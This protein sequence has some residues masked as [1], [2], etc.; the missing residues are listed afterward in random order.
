MV[1]SEIDNILDRIL[2]EQP[3]SSDT[4]Q[5]DWLNEENIQR[6]FLDF[7]S[8]LAVVELSAGTEYLNR[9]FEQI[10]R[11]GVLA[12]GVIKE[13]LEDTYNDKVYV[14]LPTR[15]GKEKS[16]AVYA[17]PLKNF[18]L[19][20]F[21][22]IESDIHQEELTSLRSRLEELEKLS[23]TDPLT[24]AWNRLPLERSVD[25]E[26]SRSQRYHHP[27][28][29][30][31]FDVDYFKKVNDV[32]GHAVGDQVL[33]SLVAL[34]R[35]NIRASDSIYRWGGE[36]FVLLATSTHHRAGAL[37]AEK[38]RR[39]VEEY[40][41]PEVGKVTI[42][43]G[44]AEFLPGDSQ[45]SWFRRADTSLYNAKESGRNCVVVDSFGGSDI[46][47]T[48]HGRHVVE[49]VWH[50]IYECGNSVID[51]QHEALF[52]RANSI[53][54]LALNQSTDI[55]LQNELDLLLDQIKTHFEDEEEILQRCHYDHLEQHKSAHRKL[56]DRAHQLKLEVDSGEINV[57]ALLE[58]V[59]Y[60]VVAKH[61]LA[62]DRDY[63]SA[64]EESVVKS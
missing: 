34:V 64:I 26:I 25:T 39:K 21:D 29:L 62:A 12:A 60:D 46:W 24:G 11:N 54:S 14:T 44:V 17:V 8:P 1:Y 45:E 18:T 15:D 3:Y 28:T 16:V 53:I 57:G 10:F 9:R 43:L 20:V 30:I 13:L 41:F 63:F 55:E 56:L 36:E 52:E 48:E 49:L 7:P 2:S 59:A 23:A 6:L 35:R 4:A 40:D 58:Y 61:L 32:F 37:L 51:L 50:D 38:I 31:F 27:A 22:E 19:L 47:A 42:S 5:Y 33:I